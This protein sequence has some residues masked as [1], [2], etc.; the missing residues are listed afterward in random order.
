MLAGYLLGLMILMVGV[1]DIKPFCFISPDMYLIATLFYLLLSYAIFP[2]K[3]FKYFSIQ[4]LPFWFIIAGIILSVIPASLFHGQ[5][6][7]QSVITY[8]SQMLWL[9]IPVVLRLK[10]SKGA[11]FKS[12]LIFTVIMSFITIAHALMPSLFLTPQESGAPLN[13]EFIVNGFAVGSIP[14]IISMERLNKSFNLRSL[15]VVIFCF[16]FFYIVQNRT[17]LIAIAVTTALMLMSSK[18]EY[19]Y[20]LMVAILALVGFFVF[21]TIDT[22][23]ALLNET[24]SDLGDSDYNRNKSLLYFFSP[25]ANPSWLTYI[26]GNGFLSAHSS[27]LMADMMSEGIYNSDLGF[28]GFWNQFGL[29]PIIAFFIL[30]IKGLFGKNTSLVAKGCAAFML[31]TSM[32]I[33]YYANITALVSFIFF[34]Y[35]IEE[36]KTRK[37]IIVTKSNGCSRE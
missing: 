29:L 27:S 2:G 6:V 12:T 16:I 8:R 7:F 32:T 14:L 34:Y 28:V 22:W 9:S 5:S 10:P 23:T 25:L 30:I 33:G 18:S 21:R 17:S 24:V 31:V 3:K 13:A 20:V 4:T 35:F 1:W 15:A 11:I 36:R 26:L 19:K 37:Y